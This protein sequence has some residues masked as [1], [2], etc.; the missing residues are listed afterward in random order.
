MRNVL[1]GDPTK[2]RMLKAA[3]M[4]I[5]YTEEYPVLQSGHPIWD[6]ANSDFAGIKPAVAFVPRNTTSPKSCLADLSLAM[7]KEFHT[8]IC[9]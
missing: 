7:N 8:A 6:A 9:E 2:D 5:G 1:F 3:L 4:A